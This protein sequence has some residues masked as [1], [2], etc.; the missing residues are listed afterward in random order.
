MPSVF[1]CSPILELQ[2]SSPHV[3][4]HK[5][6]LD[7]VWIR[8]AGQVDGLLRQGEGHYEAPGGRVLGQGDRPSASGRG[9]NR[10]HPRAP[11]EGGVRLSL[12]P[13]AGIPSPPFVHGLMFYYG[14]EFHDLAPESILQIS[15][16]IVVCEAFLHITLTLDCG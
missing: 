1:L 5:K 11:R 16:F 3:F 12:R 6:A 14:L 4:R 15:S 7:H 8:S 2:R 13:R 9:A 10:T